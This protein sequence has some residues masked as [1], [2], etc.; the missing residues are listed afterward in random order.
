MA[1]NFSLDDRIWAINGDKTDPDTVT[2]SEANLLTVAE[3]NIDSQ[4]PFSDIMNWEQFR[5]SQ[6][7]NSIEQ[8][9]IMEWSAKTKYSEK[10]LALSDSGQIY[11]SRQSGN[12]NHP[13]A[14]T[15]WW[16]EYVPTGMGDMLKSV[17]DSNGNGV[18]DKSSSIDGINNAA[19]AVYYGKD[20]SGTIGFHAIPKDGD[21]K[22]SVYDTNDN[23][24]VDTSDSIYGVDTSGSS[25]YYGTDQNGSVGFYNLPPN[26][27][28]LKSIYDTTDSGRVDISEG[29]FGINT[30]PNLSYYGKDENGTPGFYT[31]LDKLPEYAKRWPTAAEVGALAAD[32]K[33]KDSE[34]LNGVAEFTTAT[35]ETIVK[36]DADADINARAFKST[37]ATQVGDVLDGANVAFRNNNTDDSTIRF[38]DKATFK[39]WLALSKAN[40]GLSNVPNYPISHIASGAAKS[41]Q[42]FASEFALNAVWELA[43]KALNTASSG[44]TAS[45][46][47][48]AKK[49]ETSRVIALNGDVTGSVNFDGS[50]GVNMSTTVADNSHRHVWGNID[51]IPEYAKRWPTAAEA[52]ALEARGTAINSDKLQNMDVDA[53]KS[54][55]RVGLVSESRKINNK[56][57]STDINLTKSDIGLG[58]VPN[59]HI[60]DSITDNNS[61]QFASSA[62]VFALSKMLSGG[63]GKVNWLTQSTTLKSKENYISTASVTSTFPSTADDGD[64]IIY[65]NLASQ[66]TINGKFISV[67][68]VESSSLPVPELKGYILTFIWKADVSRWLYIANKTG[69]QREISYKLYDTAGSYTYTTPFG[70]STLLFIAVGAGAGAGGGGNGSASTGGGSGGAGG[71]S[72]LLTSSLL[73]SYNITIGKG[74]NGGRGAGRYTAQGG[75]NGSDGGDTIIQGL[76]V[77]G[78]GK[79]GGGGSDNYGRGGPGTGGLGG[80]SSGGSVNINGGNGRNSNKNGGTGGYPVDVLGNIPSGLTATQKSIITDAVPAGKY[81]SSG[82]MNQ[83]G[84]GLSGGSG[85]YGGG[86]G[87]GGGSSAQDKNVGSG[88]NGGDG[89]ILILEI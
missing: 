45:L 53:I 38:A 74:G 54:A 36:R 28:M 83:Y 73:S 88:G 15:S 26:G 72:A 35:A 18:V 12:K 44:G 52:G 84:N 24:R 29:V 41:K 14:D 32:A 48:E 64:E 23:G 66:G 2:T 13:L 7:L 62:A 60:S 4:G 58:N 78:G 8:L 16:I 20:A 30:A 71:Y 9:G 42:K 46:A 85:A 47:L 40:V 80:T 17:Y 50:Q 1:R 39:K 65:I 34:L 77:A 19:N 51:N 3:G 63:S 10:G 89:Y 31:I 57:L 43:D 49:L 11:Q 70:V 82:A 22:K 6:M 86:G 76:I 59:A 56:N 5:V 68:G 79:K 67:G 33:S 81:G 21:M 55:A 87:G 37:Y 27:D 75:S 25:K 69:Y 61:N